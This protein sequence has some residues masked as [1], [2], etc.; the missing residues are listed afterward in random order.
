MALLDS[1]LAK[2]AKVVPRPMIQRIAYR[3]VAGET[4]AEALSKV[5]EPST[6]YGWSGRPGA[7]T[8]LLLTPRPTPTPW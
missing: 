2:A 6:C 5:S 7:R 8:S 3:Y 4:L 1:A